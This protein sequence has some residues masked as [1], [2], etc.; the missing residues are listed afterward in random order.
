M[1]KNL[2]WLNDEQ[3]Q[4]IA[5]HLPTDVRGVERVD[6]RRGSS[7]ALFMCSRAAA[8]GATAHQSMARIASNIIFSAHSLRAKVRPAH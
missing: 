5:R 3:W 6:D 1:R 2:F 4:R 8:A 7:A